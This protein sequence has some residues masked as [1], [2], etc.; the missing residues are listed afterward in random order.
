M[1]RQDAKDAKKAA[2]KRAAPCSFFLLVFLASFASWRFILFRRDAG[3]AL[4]PPLLKA[5]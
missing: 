5:G 2:E 3:A 4:K 1:N